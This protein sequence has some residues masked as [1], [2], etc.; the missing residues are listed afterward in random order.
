[1]IA[2][3][4]AARSRPQSLSA[5]IDDMGF[6]TLHRSTV[7][8][9]LKA[10]QDMGM[11]ELHGDKKSSTWSA[12]E[13]LLREV[14]RGQLNEPLSKRPRVPYQEGF[15]EEYIPNKSAYLSK[16]EIA[17]LHRQCAIGSAE[18]S[19]LT[20]RD[21]SHFLCGLSYASSS[22]E[23]NVYDF[24]A[25]E[26]LLLDGLE[27]ENATPTETAMVL[28]HHMAVRHLVDN[29]HFPNRKNDVNVKVRD[30]KEIHGLLSTNLLKDPGMCGAVRH[31]P[32]KINQSSYIPLA[33]HELIERALSTVCQ[34]ASQIEDPYEQAFFLLVHLPYLQP[35]EDC[36]KRTSRVACN[37]PL[38][39]KGVVPM[40][41]MDVN[42][43]SYN[44]GLV[45]IYERNNTALLS[46]VFVDGYM[47]STERFEIMQR[48]AAPNEVQIRYRAAAKEVIR[49]LILDGDSA[50]PND[51]APG[52][53]DAF[54]V[55]VEQE[56]GLLRAGNIGALVRYG[57]REGDIDAWMQENGEAELPGR[58]RL[59]TTPG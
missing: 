57:L 58:E 38:L 56:L 34:K 8:R 21:Q 18:F 29:I 9:W 10:A 4:L 26:K 49:S 11:V 52:D 17:R 50:A 31:A 53:V 14:L 24:I 22:M 23:G 16:K 45:G 32:V 35:F 19:S 25:T 44:E 3:H 1:M 54:K 36:N 20:M 43:T 13:A 2:R 55:H 28:N 12:S 46:E 27:K 5:L 7:W 41:W 51:V 6:D 42:Q 37:V 39:R 40:S 47:H 15:L 33:V 48:S 59:R 30:I